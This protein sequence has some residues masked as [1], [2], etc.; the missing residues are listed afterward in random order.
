[1]ARTL[2]IIDDATLKSLGG[3]IIGKM[4]DEVKS[5]FSFAPKFTILMIAPDKIPEK[6]DFTDS[7]V[8]VVATDDNV[9][10]MQN[11]AEQQELRS[12][13]FAIKNN[14]LNIK[15]ASFKRNSAKPE[16]GEVKE[17]LG[18]ARRRSQKLATECSGYL[19]HCVGA[20]RCA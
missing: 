13:E 15:L 17:A 6:I 9:T 18:P 14:N 12:M 5:I 2:F 1:M 3:T 20:P 7:I 10:A 19:G 11:Q 16:R 8:K 4:I